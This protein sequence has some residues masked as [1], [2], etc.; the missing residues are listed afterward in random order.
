MEIVII[1]MKIDSRLPEL[2]EGK[3][4]SGKIRANPYA[5]FCSQIFQDGHETEHETKCGRYQ[6]GKSL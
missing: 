3:N 1:Q 6:N 4:S 2:L 5:T